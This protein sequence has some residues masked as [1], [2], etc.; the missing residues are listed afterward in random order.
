LVAGF[1][2]EPVSVKPL[3]NAENAEIAEGK[4]ILHGIRVSL[5]MGT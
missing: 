4:P 3:L 5:I 1:P 2:I